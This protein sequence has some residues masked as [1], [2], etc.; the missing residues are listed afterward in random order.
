[1]KLIVV[2]SFVVP[3]LAAV[4]PSAT[5]ENGED[6]Y[7]DK[8]AMCHD[9]GSDKAPRIGVPE[10]WKAR[11]SKGR[12]GLL[13]SALKGVAGSAMAPK[14]GFFQLPDAE[15]A[16]AVDYMLSRA[17]FS[18][19]DAA[20]AAS[21]REA[22]EQAH[23]FGVRVECTDGAVVLTGLAEDADAVRAAVGAARAVPGVREVE[24]R[25]APAAVFE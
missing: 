15:V 17:G 16:Q 9:A 1:M 3:G 6:I 21:V 24:N 19:E 13:R 10:D 18:A 25:V 20:M 22:L 2:I 14:G 12:E 7:R 8:C 11:F 4:A 5:A 23:I